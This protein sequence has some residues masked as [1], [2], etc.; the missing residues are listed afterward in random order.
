MVDP[1]SFGTCI[2][3]YD[4]YVVYNFSN[5]HIVGRVEDKLYT[6]TIRKFRYNYD[7][8]WKRGMC[9]I[10]D[11]IVRFFDVSYFNLSQK[12]VV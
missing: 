3:E 1:S 7:T 12:S 4:M 6:I 9:I 10:H 11:R 8:I 2:V 5:D